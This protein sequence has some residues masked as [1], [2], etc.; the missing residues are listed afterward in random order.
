MS[1]DTTKAYSMAVKARLMVAR[2]RR[3]YLRGIS[4]ARAERPHDSAVGTK[5]AQS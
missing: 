2:L 1:P 3:R 5:G 4:A